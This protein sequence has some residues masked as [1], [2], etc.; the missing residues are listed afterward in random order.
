M[1]GHRSVPIRARIADGVTE[2]TTAPGDGHRDG[3]TPW[4]PHQQVMALPPDPAPAADGHGADSSNSGIVADALGGLA[5]VVDRQVLDPT[6]LS[7]GRD[8]SSSS[9]GG[10]SD[11]D[12]SMAGAA[13]GK[14]SSPVNG[15]VGSGSSAGGLATVAG[16]AVA[17]SLGWGSVVESGSLCGGVGSGVAWWRVPNMMGAR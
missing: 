4:Q 15:R 10:W 3:R 11:V 12:A 17:G 5:S 14:G 13:A 6:A 16:W 9:V 2:R 7:V 1:L 8:G